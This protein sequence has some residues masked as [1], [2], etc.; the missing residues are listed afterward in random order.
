[1]RSGRRQRAESRILRNTLAA[2]DLGKINRV[3]C[4][5]RMTNH[6]RRAITH[7]GK[8]RNGCIELKMTLIGADAFA[9][10]NDHR[11]I[12]EDANATRQTFFTRIGADRRQ[13]ARAI[14]GRQ[15]FARILAAVVHAIA[16]V[17]AETG[18]GR[19]EYAADSVATRLVHDETGAVGKT[20]GNVAGTDRAESVEEARVDD[21]ATDFVNDCAR[22]RQSIAVRVITA[23]TVAL[24]CGANAEKYAEARGRRHD[25]A[26]AVGLTTRTIVGYVRNT[27]ATNTGFTVCK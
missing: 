7:T 14:G 19:G 13:A 2:E 4:E 21:C 9:R 17:V 25:D 20:T 1:M 24:A 8:R 5:G 26:G 23:G 12:S 10:F 3:Y 6:S 22:L 18:A 27:F 15:T 11:P 16:V